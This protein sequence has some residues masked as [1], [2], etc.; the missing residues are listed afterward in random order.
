MHVIIL[1]LMNFA[2]LPLSQ[3][4]IFLFK[5]LD[6]LGVV[7]LF[8]SL[9]VDLLLRYFLDLKHNFVETVLVNQTESESLTL[10][11]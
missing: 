8:G 2:F 9:F 4:L 11:E 10:V 5:V 1:H 7:D 3:V 6:N